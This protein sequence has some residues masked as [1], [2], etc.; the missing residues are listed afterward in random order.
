MSRSVN[1]KTQS[2]AVSPIRIGNPVRFK[3]AG[4][5]LF[6]SRQ[7]LV[8]NLL[9]LRLCRRFRKTRINNGDFSTLGKISVLSVTNRYLPVHHFDFLKI[10]KSQDQFG[11]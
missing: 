8:A 4:V 3:D 6:Q 10:A 9:L 11:K 7:L 1:A 5:L 2:L